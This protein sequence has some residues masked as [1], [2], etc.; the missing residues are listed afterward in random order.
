[1]LGESCWE[2]Y[3][4][5]GVILGIRLQVCSIHQ[6][7]GEKGIASFRIRIT[8]NTWKVPKWKVS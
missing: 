7:A 6:E 5:Q 3:G 1:M 4:E 2:V 8:K